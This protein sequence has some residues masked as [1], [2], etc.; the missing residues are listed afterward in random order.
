MCCFVHYARGVT[1]YLHINYDFFVARLNREYF[2][3]IKKMQCKKGESPRT[4]STPRAPKND[5]KGKNDGTGE[6]DS[7]QILN[8]YFL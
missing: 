1:A 6:N 5:S 4:S 2:G 8:A 7:V 3:L